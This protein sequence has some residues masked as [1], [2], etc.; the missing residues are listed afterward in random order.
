MRRALIVAGAVFIAV[1]LVA[2]GAVAW[3]FDGDA[4]KAL[5]I[6]Q[7]ERTTGRTLTIAGPVDLAWALSPTLVLNDVSLS[8]PPDFAD[9]V[10]AHIARIEARIGLGELFQRR[11]VIE[12]LVVVQPSANLAINAAGRANWDFTPPARTGT[13]GAASAPHADRFA[14]SIAAVDITDATL[15]FFGRTVTA[16]HLNYALDTGAVSGALLDNGQTLTVSGTAG[17]LANAPIDLH[18]AGAGLAAGLLGTS[19]AAVLTMSAPDL[20]ALSPLVGRPLPPLHN[21]SLQTT[22]P[23]L[24]AIQ[25]QIGSATVGPLAIGAATLTATSRT[26]PAAITANA[27]LGPL[28]LTV[29]GHIGSIAAL[30]RGPV[31]IDISATGSNLTL[32]A[33]GTLTTA[34]T[35]SLQLGAT[36]PDLAIAGLPELRALQAK[37]G[38]SLQPGTAALTGLQMT[39]AQGDLQGDLTL[40]YGSHPV[41]KGALA[42]HQFDVQLAPPPPAPV[43]PTAGAAAPAAPPPRP[44]RL[45][46][47]T[48]LPFDELQRADADLGLTV[49]SLHLAGA[50]YSNVSAHAALANGTL[51][52]DPLTLSLG[53]ATAHAT[54]QADASPRAVHA[55]IAA[56]GV[57]VAAV[58]A[59]FGDTAAG[60][61]TLDLRADL[62][63]AGNSV[64]ALA[65]TLGG[66]AGLAIV[67]AQ[68]D[69][70][71]LERW[72]AGPLRSAGVSLDGSGMTTIRCGAVAADVAGGHVRFATLT[73][74]ATRLT[75]DGEGNVDLGT[76]GID[77]H[78]RPEL[79]VGGGLSVPIRVGGTLAAPKMQL[80]AGALASGRV[81]IM[82]GGPPPP[83]RC[84]PALAAAREGQ[85]GASAPP[86][87]PAPARKL[88]PADILRG[89][90]R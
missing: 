66:Q 30:L 88:K 54:I 33:A 37:A 75:L 68:I 32:T 1:P 20:A 14:V 82:L 35:G 62:T 46:P 70:A 52:L 79:R 25:V 90:L 29:T 87:A 61:G 16:P 85:A 55:T 9:P 67:D 27:T 3:W 69:N 57:P 48:K 23:A 4:I 63:G 64:R 42:S 76:E 84:G 31:P 17:L 24:S 21:V 18:L 36:S 15:G 8:N 45:I 49:G 26:D 6:E 86:A 22:L 51:R 56:P 71:L 80:D 41:L 83:D 5:L 34:G 53:A 89:L 10:M 78:L 65:A 50:T 44:D 77:L 47:D 40:Q 58:L 7:A 43:T 60:T 74:D 28:P 12:R 11:V 2:A 19:D 39:S 81:G 13:P 73:L 72:A 38:L 59:L